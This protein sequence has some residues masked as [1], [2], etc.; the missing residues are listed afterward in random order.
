MGVKNE[1]DAILLFCNRKK[2]KLLAE[3]KLLEA[4]L[5]EK[6]DIDIRLILTAGKE[7]LEKALLENGQYKKPLIVSIGGDGSFNLLIN[8]LSKLA[9][10]PVVA[11]YPSGTANDHARVIGYKKDRLIAGIVAG[12]TSR[13]DLIE[14]NIAGA[15]RFLYY[16]HSYF[17]IGVTGLTARGINRHHLSL[18]FQVLVAF[19]ELMK[20]RPV[21]VQKEKMNHISWHSITEMC[22]FLKVSR[23]G[24]VNDGL[25]EVYKLPASRFNRIKL[26]KTVL[27][28]W[29]SNLDA[30]DQVKES[31]VFIPKE[32]WSQ[33]DGEELLLPGQSRIT[34][35]AKKEELEVLDY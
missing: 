21:E 25:L 20:F 9:I 22:R 12:R 3:T 11:I 17:A 24:R 33:L 5:K 13:I 26:L 15:E 1:F 35:K 8:V 27:K 2:P 6:I 10:C 29:I 18:F 30:R 16:A 4:R 23:C 34:V 14:I 19:F 7:E 28:G 32:T 31:V